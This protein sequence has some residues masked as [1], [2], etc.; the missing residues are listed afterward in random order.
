M[1]A[2]SFLTVTAAA[3]LGLLLLTGPALAQWGPGQ[4]G[5]LANRSQSDSGG[6]YSAPTAPATSQSFFYG[7][8]RGDRNVRIHMWVPENAQVWFEGSP[9]AQTGTERDFVSPPLSA[10]RDYTYHVRVKWMEGGRPLDEVRDITVRAGDR[11]DLKFLRTASANY[12][13]PLEETGPTEAPAIPASR[14]SDRTANP[15]YPR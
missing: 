13:A 4:Q 2:K 7:P 5:P 3:M 14:E 11:I 9:T 12:F 8:D 10:G 6:F 15:Y 1:F